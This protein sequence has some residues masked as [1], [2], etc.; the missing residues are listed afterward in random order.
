VLPWFASSIAA[1]PAYATV[2]M[3]AV[4][5]SSVRAPLTA[6]LLLFELTRDYRIVLPLMAAVGFSVWLTD[7]VKQRLERLPEVA[8]TNVATKPAVKL[9]VVIEEEE[10]DPLKAILQRFRVG[11]VM[12]DAGMMTFPD[13]LSMTDAGLLLT[14][15]GRH[16]ALILDGEK[17]LVGILTLQDVN[18]ALA[19]WNSQDGRGRSPRMQT[20]G[21]VCS[22]NLLF[23]FRDESVV[24]AMDRMAARG[25]HQL[26]VVDREDSQVLLGLLC[27]DGID[28][29]CNVAM[30]KEALENY[31][32][33]ETVG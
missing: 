13:S 10:V 32:T 5:A 9:E 30:T 33:A 28:L 26:P 29:A 27:E 24:E 25:L 4:L 14:D 21:E 18:R 1:P 11:D 7:F 16:S 8:A 6:V 17:K 12:Q 22:R 19:R 20:S 2:G 23:A 31:F 15:A 3:A